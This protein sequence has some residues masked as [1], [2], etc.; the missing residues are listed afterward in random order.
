MKTNNLS[1]QSVIDGYYKGMIIEQKKINKL[2]VNNFELQS[3]SLKMEESIQHDKGVI[4][5]QVINEVDQSTNKKR[6]SNET[7]RK[8]EVE[9]R[10]SRDRTIR[11]LRESIKRNELLVLNNN[12]EIDIFKISIFVTKQRIKLYVDGFSYD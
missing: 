10:L 3:S 12:N 9:S 6:F 7:A 1:N 5:R 2:R 8:Q 4:V 11:E